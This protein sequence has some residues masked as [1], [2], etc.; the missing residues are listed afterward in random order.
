MKLIDLSHMMN[1][2]TPGWVGYG[3]NKMFYEQN[4]QTGGIVA[5]RIDTAL[6]AGT[7]IDGAMHG[8]D[9]K[10]DMGSYPMD[11]FVGKGVVVDISEHIEDWT[12]ITPEMIEAAPVDVEEGDILILH[13]GFHKYYEGGPQQDLERYFCMHPGG[14]VELLEWMLDKKLNWF[15]VDTGSGDH[16]MNTSIRRMRPDL[17]K[18]FEAQ[19]GMSCEDFFGEY[20]YTHS[21]SGRKAR[22]NIFPFHIYGFNED[23]IHAENVG[24]DI[25]LAANKRCII[26]AFPWRY[27]GLEACPCR[28]ICFYDVGEDVE[29]VG[30]VAKALSGA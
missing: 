27:D 16:P 22:N 29:A 17:T 15:G 3:G 20:E 6:H 11:R 18:R 2:H 12:I 14:N 10:G 1:V 13:T 28:I 25:E 7:H 26:G 9:R 8:A 30:A 23:L 5:Q 19:I 21:L 24:G 4:L